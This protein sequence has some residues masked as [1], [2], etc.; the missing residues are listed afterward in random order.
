MKMTWLQG[1]LPVQMRSV[2]DALQ[3]LGD[4][5]MQRRRWNSAGQGEVSSLTESVE[6]LFGDSG[7]GDELEKGHSGLN[8]ATVNALDTLRRTLAR[9]S[10][11]GRGRSP[12]EI[13]DD[14][15]MGEVRRLAREALALVRAEAGLPT[16]G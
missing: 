4:I 10:R 5:E 3:E 14:P 11:S 16:E 13:I 7:L 1:A 2:L 9:L 15:V 8:G 12:N 6:S